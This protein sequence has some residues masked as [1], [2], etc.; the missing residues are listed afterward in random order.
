MSKSASLENRLYAYITT[1]TA[2]GPVTYTDRLCM[3]VT[4]DGAK[5]RALNCLQ[6]LGQLING[7]R[8]FVN[9]YWCITNN[10]DIYIPSETFAVVLDWRY[11]N[12]LRYHS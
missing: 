3:T 7:P 10:N 9:V 4:N 5:G 8:S 1:A 12:L 6:M 11:N 2:R